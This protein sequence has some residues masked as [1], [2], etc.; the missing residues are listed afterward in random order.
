MSNLV[1]ADPHRPGTRLSV[2][3]G[4]APPIPPSRREDNVGDRLARGLRFE[5]KEAGWA[6][7]GSFAGINV[8]LVDDDYRNVFA[9]TALL[10]RGGAEVVTAESGREAID[11][12][13]STPAINLVLMDIMMPDMDG[14]ATMRAIRSIDRFKELPIVAVTGKV[15][16]GERQRC[17]E[18][19]ADD[20][21]PKPVD[22][23]EFVT[24]LSRW[25]W[26]LRT[27]SDD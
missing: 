5:A 11:L 13:L 7:N 9:M 14:Y 12:L 4:A 16:L 15:V 23:A 20:Y 26:T 1:V 19:G 10:E 2:F 27:G 18:A 6:G 8:L 3:A 21:V 25:S 24:K 22:V 17:I